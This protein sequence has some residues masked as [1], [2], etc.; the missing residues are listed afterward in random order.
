MPTCTCTCSLQALDNNNGYRNKKK[1]VTTMGK[2]GLKEAELEPRKS[3]WASSPLPTGI[4][5]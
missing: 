5:C 1:K 4:R 2:G 3:M